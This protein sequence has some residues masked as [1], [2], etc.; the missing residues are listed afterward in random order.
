MV[1]LR[2]KSRNE[3]RNGFRFTLPRVIVLAG[4]VL[5]FGLPAVI[6]W[7]GGYL[8]TDAGEIAVVRNGGWFDDNQIRLVVDPA[9]SLTWSGWWSTAHRYPAQQRFYT[10][11]ANGDTHNGQRAGVDV[12]NVPSGDGVSMGI[13]G[14][15]YFTLNLDHGTVRQFD[16]KFG[17]RTFRG[18]D[19]EFR[20]AWDGDVG[21]SSFLDQIVRPVIDNAMREQVNNFRCAE[22]VSSCA[23]VQNQN[24]ATA[25]PV[26]GQANNANIAAVQNAI[27][28]SVRRDL[29]ENLGGD[30][31]TG[32]TFVLSRV[33]L[34]ETVQ[35]AVERTQAA[36]A[37]IGESQ[38]K[39]TQAQAEAQAN[40]QRQRGYN[41]C[42][43]CAQIDIIKAIPQN[44]TVYAPGAAAAVPL[45]PAH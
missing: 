10:I 35:Q 24:A 38:A 19:G 42:P 6:G 29:K 44:V 18:A 8:K 17:T 22:L 9:S 45:G 37:Q 1:R 14:T 12:V 20:H 15:F 21:W 33:T 26:A 5:A 23:L 4:V 31:L 39:A 43:A 34:P 28:A 3:P 27:T 16:D 32:I 36:Y 7:L 25:P 41:A 11:T 30:F 13:E 2:R 40:E